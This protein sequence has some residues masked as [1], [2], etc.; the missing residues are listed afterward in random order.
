[1]SSVDKVEMKKALQRKCVNI[2]EERIDNARFAV[3]E[4]EDMLLA[5]K[6]NPD[7]YD[8]DFKEQKRQEMEVLAKRLNEAEEELNRL[9]RIRVNQEMETVGPG[10]IVITDEVSFFI[11]VALGVIHGEEKA[12]MGISTSAPIYKSMSGK[13]VGSSFSFRDKNYT[14]QEIF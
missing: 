14:I 9:R 4:I 8:E 12:Y 6:D 13:E 2:L 5:T 7:Q 10:A 11:G 3:D 1:M